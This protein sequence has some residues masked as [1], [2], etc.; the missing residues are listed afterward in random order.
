MEGQAS[1]A[2]D[3]LASYAADAAREVEGVR[4]LV[5]SKLPR[6]SGVRVS[7]EDGA[8]TVEVHLELSRGVA[9]AAVGRNVQQRVAEYLQQMAGARPRAVHV[10]VDAFGPES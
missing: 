3:V 8:V 9:A 10:V 1:V 6:H 2:A 4:N 5:E 7:D